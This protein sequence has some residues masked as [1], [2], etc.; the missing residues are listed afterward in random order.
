MPKSVIFN[1]EART[2]L[3]T[4]AEVVAKAVGS[5]LGPKANNVAIERPFG[6]PSVLHD[7]VSVA[8]EIDLKDPMENLGAQLIK[9]AAQKTNDNAGDGTTTATILTYALAS[10]AIKNIA[11]GANPMML[12]KG[13]EMASK[14]IITELK[15][16]AK[17]I[18]SNDEVKQIATISAQDETIGALIAGAIKKL[19]ND[20]II[21]V[22][23]SNTIGMNVE[24]KEGM[25][26]DKGWLSPYFITDPNTMEAI[27]EEPWVI[28]TD[29]K[30]NTNVEFTKWAMNLE[31]LYTMNSD[32]YKQWVES[33]PQYKGVSYD[34]VPKELKQIPKNVVFIMGEL[35]GIALASVVQNKIQGFFNVLAIQAPGYGD[36]QKEYL[37]DLAIVT[38]GTLISSETGGS[39]STMKFEDFGHAKKI[40]STKD[41][42]M[43]I[44]GE[45][46][47][48][49]IKK[50][51]TSLEH[52][53]NGNDISEFDKEKL[54]E[55][56]AKL[57]SGI[58][59]INVGAPSE[60]EM[61]EKKERCIDAIEATKAAVEEGIVPGGEVAY[62]NAVVKLTEFDKLPKDTKKGISGDVETGY[63]LVLNAI[64]KPFKTLMLNSG[65]DP[66]QM[67]ER[68]DGE[69]DY[70]NYNI[71]I[72]VL[73]GQVKDMIKAGIIDPVKVSRV[74]L[75]NAVSTAG[76]ILTT[77]CLITEIKES[78]NE[79]GRVPQN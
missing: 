63:L 3:L 40:V 15:G 17:K 9:E 72:D 20:C 35:T 8:K 7:G 51:V 62:L 58:A 50:R 26:F 64:E 34:Q 16:L 45:G 23:E 71:G 30:M 77:N 47:K 36:K 1:E 19:G 70:Q 41:S 65:Y 59:V 55:R 68:L 12:R 52:I 44:D 31:K 4:G 57:T 37:Q 10:E 29:I 73:D 14:D 43:I 25:Q 33:N 32:A 5:T 69:N 67:L 38:G 60:M 46:S 27:V 21:A 28:I 24:Y 49:D 22:E 39:L 42:T 78:K 13:M 18:K 11:A 54:K 2:K 66:G 61:R 53:L 76:A 74:A 6:S 75:E 56:I 48:E 79:D